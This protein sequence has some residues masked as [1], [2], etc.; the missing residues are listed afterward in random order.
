MPTSCWTESFG[1][2]RKALG[3]SV[4][5]IRARRLV[6]NRRTRRGIG[7]HRKIVCTAAFLLS[8]VP[9]VATAEPITFTFQIS[10]IQR[11]IDFRPYESIPDTFPLRLTVS[12]E[13]VSSGGV[14]GNDTVPPPSLRFRSPGPRFR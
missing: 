11:S 4:L 10:E 5:S 12:R 6:W 2:L 8:I 1:V 3:T 13:P 14:E 7:W 9:C